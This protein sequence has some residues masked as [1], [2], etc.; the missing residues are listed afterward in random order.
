LKG[1]S[2]CPV[3]LFLQFGQINWYT[4][5]LLYVLVLGTLVFCCQV[6]LD[7][8]VGSERDF[9]IEL[10]NSF[11]MNL[12]FLPTYV[13]FAIFFYLWSSSF[14]LFPLLALSQT[15][16]SYLLFSKICCIVSVAW[17]FPHGSHPTQN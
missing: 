7:C 12:V 11:I 5:V 4:S 10:L 3:Y 15:E 6:F 17:N 14:L 1:I 13:N 2:V 16:T 9:N 8:V